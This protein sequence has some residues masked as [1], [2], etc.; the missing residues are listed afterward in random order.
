MSMVES[1][2]PTAGGCEARWR[3]NKSYRQAG[4]KCGARARYTL[5]VGTAMML[6]CPYHFGITAKELTRRKISY[7]AHALPT[8]EREPPPIAAPE[9]P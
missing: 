2:D 8:A 4:T 1:Y 6:V 5:S 3:R 7:S 9:N